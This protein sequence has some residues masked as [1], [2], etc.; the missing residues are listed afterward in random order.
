MRGY[1]TMSNEERNS[2]LQQHSAFYN[3]Y[4][5]GNLTLNQQPLLQDQG[6][7]DSKGITVNSRGEVSNYKNHLVNESE[8]KEYV[9]DDMDVSDVESAYD[10][11]SGGPEQFD[12]ENN[13]FE[14]E[15]EFDR[16]GGSDDI[17]FPPSSGDEESDFSYSE[18]SYG[19]DLDSI[20]SMF[21]GSISADLDDELDGR[22]D[23]EGEVPAY[24]FDSEGAMDV[25]LYEEEQCEGCGSEMYEEEQCEGCGSEM[26]EG[27]EVCEMCGGEMREGECM[28]CGGMY[29]GVDEDLMESLKKEKNRI[30]EMFDRFSKFN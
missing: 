16:K 2:I 15:L 13:D 7:A 29:E 28:E 3:G 21:D 9:A 4:A 1:S 25:D 11:E 10:F 8:V 6:P 12:D 24:E 14:T 20:M 18:D 27:S 17:D 22:E 5:T 26:Y 23:Y 30:T 19:M